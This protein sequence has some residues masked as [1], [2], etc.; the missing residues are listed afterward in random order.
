MNERAL[1]DAIRDKVS[2]VDIAD[3]PNLSLSEK[4]SH[5]T[6]G[7]TNSLNRRKG[8]HADDGKNVDYWRGWPADTERIARAI[9]KRFTDLGMDGATGGGANPAYVYIF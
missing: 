3:Q 7:V 1:A 2:K 9:E 8:E 5:W 4:Y 6:I